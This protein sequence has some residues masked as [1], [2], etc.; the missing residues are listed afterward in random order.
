MRMLRFSGGP[1]AAVLLEREWGPYACLASNMLLIA[2]YHAA[3]RPH[4]PFVSDAPHSTTKSNAAVL[5]RRNK[6]RQ[7]VD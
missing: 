4:P 6:D 5:C 3:Q 7:E 1:L 2:S